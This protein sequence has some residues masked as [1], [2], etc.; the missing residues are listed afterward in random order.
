[1]GAVVE[2]YYYLLGVASGI[3]QAAKTLRQRAGELFLGKQDDKAVALRDAADM[4]DLLAE[5]KEEYARRAR[6]DQIN[7]TPDK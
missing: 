2:D 7:E 1:M 5:A 3:D 4:L 6:P